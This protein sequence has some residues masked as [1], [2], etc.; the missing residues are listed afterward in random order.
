MSV[1]EREHAFDCTRED[2][3]GQS[4]SVTSSVSGWRITEALKGMRTLL[5]RVQRLSVASVVPTVSGGGED[6][7]HV[8]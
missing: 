1:N 3:R 5:Q 2:A 4:T 6:R 7:G 8:G